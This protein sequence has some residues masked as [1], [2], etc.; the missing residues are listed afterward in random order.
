LCCPGLAQRDVRVLSRGSGPLRAGLARGSL[1]YGI[2]N[3]AAGCRTA[4][5]VA[6]KAVASVAGTGR[7][8]R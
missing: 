5:P 4:K 1:P 8:R 2:G 3:H 7:E 6:S